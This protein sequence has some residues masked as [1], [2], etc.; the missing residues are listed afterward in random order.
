MS[1]NMG[2]D[3]KTWYYRGKYS[4]NIRLQWDML[5]NMVIPWFK[6]MEF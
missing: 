6:N 3:Q 4:K 1:K 5:K 2:N